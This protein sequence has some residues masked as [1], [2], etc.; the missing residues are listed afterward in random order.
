MSTPAFL[1]TAQASA[2]L[3]I[4][5]RTLQWHVYE[6]KHLHPDA[7]VGGDCVFSQSTLDTFKQK[8]QADYGMTIH[9]AAAYL[10]MSVAWVRRHV[11]TTKLLQPCARRGSAAVFS[12]AAVDAL[13]E[14]SHATKR[15]RKAPLLALPNG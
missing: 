14:H 1:N 6:A 9:E 13:R 12:R 11:Y 2:Y 7:K 4:A 5:V 3:G 15:E 8:H 10:G